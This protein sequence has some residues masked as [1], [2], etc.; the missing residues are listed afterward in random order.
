MYIP[1]NYSI[2]LIYSFS[3]SQILGLFMVIMVVIMLNRR[4]YYRKMIL[5]LKSDNPIIFVVGTF[6]LLIGILLVYTHNIWEWKY[7]VGITVLCWV[8]FVNSVLWLAIPEKMLSLAK[9]IF[10]GYGY[11]WVMLFIGM[12][13]CNLVGRGILLFVVNK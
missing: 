7:L 4:E 6:N 1:S 3:I 12:L 10:A 2:P 13:G 11:Y 5:S 8:V 9:Q